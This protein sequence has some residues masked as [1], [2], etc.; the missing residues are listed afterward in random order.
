MDLI[1]FINTLQRALER[2]AKALEVRQYQEQLEQLVAQRTDDLEQR[3]Q[4]IFALNAAFQKYL[5]QGL[6]IQQAYQEAQEIS[7]FR[8]FSI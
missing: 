1:E 8:S 6:S 4:E 3:K 5:T 2:R 7:P